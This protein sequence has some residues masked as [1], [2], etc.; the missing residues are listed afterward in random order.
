MFKFTTKGIKGEDGRPVTDKY[1]WKR[2]SN[3]SQLPLQQ[4]QLQAR[5]NMQYYMNIPQLEGVIT[6]PVYRHNE[7]RHQMQLMVHG[8]DEL[9]WMKDMITDPNFIRTSEWGPDSATYDPNLD[10]NFAVA[11]A[12]KMMISES[13]GV[14]SSIH[15]CVVDIITGK[16][17]YSCDF[18]LRSIRPIDHPIT[19]KEVLTAWKLAREAL[20]RY[21]DDETIVVGHNLRGCFEKLR[22]IHPRIIDTS[23]L[24]L[25]DNGGMDVLVDIVMTAKALGKNGVLGEC[26]AARQVLFKV[27]MQR[28]G[29]EWHRAVRGVQEVWIQVK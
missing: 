27:T 7:Y 25:K 5:T 17:L 24:N 11:I 10:R 3:T 6:I 4:I 21:I 9:S 15:I 2:I 8:T 1:Y 28:M 19:R 20:L 13:S 16:S 12:C 29:G 26:L 22:L 23:L 18:S 14:P